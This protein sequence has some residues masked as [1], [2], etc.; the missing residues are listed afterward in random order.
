MTDSINKVSVQHIKFTEYPQNPPFDP[1]K[2]YPEYEDEEYISKHNP[3]YKAVRDALINLELDGE[4]IN[5]S[6]WSPFKKFIK[7]GDKVVIKPNLVLDAIH[8]KAVTTHSSVLRPII[9]YAWLALKKKGEICI[10][11]APLVGADFQKIIDQTGLNELINILKERGVNVFIEDLRARKVIVNNNIW[12]GE[13]LNSEKR[14]QSIEVDLKDL[15]FFSD[16]NICINKLGEGSYNRVQIK[17]NHTSYSHKYRISKRILEADVVI[18]VPK[19]KTHK[20]AGLT[21]CLKNLVGINVDKNYLPHF[22]YGPSNY[23]GDEFPPVSFCRFF[24]LKLFK[25]ARYLFLGKLGFVFS[26]PIAKIVGIF[27][28]IHFKIDDESPTGKEEPAKKIYKIITGTD[29]AGAWQGNETIWRMI[30]DLNRIFLY[31]DSIGKLHDKIQRR[32]FYIVDGFIS[33]VH[34]APLNP[35]IY[36]ASIVF[37]GYNAAMVDRAILELAGIDFNKI[38]LYREVFSGGKRWLYQDDLFE[39]VLNGKILD[40][41]DIKP[42]IKLR[43]PDYWSFNKKNNAIT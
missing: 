41:T 38:P 31:S 27:N 4:N 25:S 12:I 16:K 8:Q 10:C 7:P 30:L 14:K 15:S 22:T 21:L 43:E 6:S 18:S 28:K 37:V 39:I 13:K 36:K 42:I 17:K 23:G 33:G 1:E 2:K 5:K 32:V 29:Y 11:D 9:D 20:K 34:N 26:K 40:H 3:V 24:L 19:L 35:E